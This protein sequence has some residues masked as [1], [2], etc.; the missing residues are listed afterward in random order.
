MKDPGINDSGVHPEWEIDPT[1]KG[2]PGGD[3]PESEDE[4]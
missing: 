4:L 1:T 3:G 2:L